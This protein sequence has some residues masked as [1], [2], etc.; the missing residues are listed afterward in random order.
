MRQTWV[1][2]NA[3]KQNVSMENILGHYGLLDGLRRVKEDELVGL[4]PFHEETR[5]SLHVSV[6]KNAFQCFGCKR[7]GNI[8]DFV[9]YKEGTNIRGAALLIAGW[10]QIDS[11]NATD[12]PVRGDSPRGGGLVPSEQINPPL[13]PPRFP[14]R[15]L[16][17]RRWLRGNSFG[18]SQT[19]A[20]DDAGRRARRHKN[21]PEGERRADAV[22]TA[23]RY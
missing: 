12:G 6:S 20:G 23:W 9:A 21:P 19:A 18:P 8:L 2:F 11:Q 3:L 13:T 15:N 14:L 16:D 4:C 7:K 22:A 17:E 5:G 10:F 1:D